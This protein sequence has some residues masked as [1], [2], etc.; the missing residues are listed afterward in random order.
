MS[1]MYTIGG[2]K[3]SPVGETLDW[4]CDPIPGL[5][6]AGDVG[7]LCEIGPQGAC[8]CSAMGTLAVRAMCAGEAHTIPGEAGTVVETLTG[9]AVAANS[10]E[11]DGISGATRTAEGFAAAVADALRKAQ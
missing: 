3:S 10:A 9:Q 6:H 8:G 11:I 5:C 4:A 7:Q 1:V 2:L